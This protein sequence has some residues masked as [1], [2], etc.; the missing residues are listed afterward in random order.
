MKHVTFKTLKIQNFLSIGKELVIDIKCGINIITGENKDKDN[1]G[2]GVGKSTIPNAMFFVLFGTT[3]KD[4]KKENIVNNFAKKNCKVTLDFCVDSNGVITNY[5]IERGISPSFCNVFVNGSQEKNLSTIPATNTY[6]INLIN[7]S[8]NLFKNIITMSM[9]NTKPFMAQKKNEKREFVEGILKLEVLKIMNKLAKD[10]YDDIFREYDTTIKI[11]TELENNIVI[12]K[13]KSAIFE[14][15]RTNRINELNKR[16][17]DIE[18][19]IKQLQS[20]II[21]INTNA[22][23]D[24]KLQLS[25]INIKLKQTNTLYNNSNNKLITFKTKLTNINEQILKLSNS[26]EKLQYWADWKDCPPLTKEIIDDLNEE[27]NGYKTNCD[28][29]IKNIEL[30]I[31]NANR[32]INDNII[33]IETLEKKGASCD[34]CKRPFTE[35]DVATNQTI[36]EEYKNKN[37]ELTILIEKY[38]NEFNE[39]KETIVEYTE[40][41]EILRITEQLLVFQV[42]QI[43]VEQ[44]IK[45]E[46]IEFKKYETQKLQYEDELTQKTSEFNNITNEVNRN[47]FIESTIVDKQK[48][49]AITT[50]DLKNV[51]TEKNTFEEL[52][53]N[54]NI[55]RTE[56][57]K[58][59]TNSKQK[60]KIY[61]VIKYVVSDEG[62]KTLI[63]KRILNTLNQKINEYLKQLDANCSLVF[64]EFFEDTIINDRGLECTYENF[65]GGEEKRID[66]ACLFTFM[67][68]RR[69]QGDVT[70]NIVFFDELL[71]S[72]LSVNGSEKVFNI[73]KDRR[74][75][76]DES[77]YIITHKKENLKNKLITDIIYLEKVGGITRIKKENT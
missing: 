48:T 20:E 57:E 41:I 14:S 1:D 13:D 30:D 4:L 42:L 60:L 66:L 64:N 59:I 2:N 35:D 61:D 68:I 45:N 50:T 17:N 12:Y 75:K 67:D 32:T 22:L 73:L 8:P 56:L 15:N 3:I 63:I 21:P 5:I 25:E 26:R 6:I 46:E 49:V 18:T 71:D 51:T 16:L 31:Y 29:G 37:I 38:N 39:I 28:K 58:Q 62:I 69:L 65:S 9:N 33:S 40:K 74:D 43:D 27:I 36:I 44:S 70:F 53:I 19:N 11:Y 47:T 52:Y 55:K 34:K 10:N 23:K 77:C 24:I 54:A 76:Y 72:A 7:T